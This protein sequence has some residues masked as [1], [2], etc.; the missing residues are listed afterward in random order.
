MRLGGR[1]ECHW[2]EESRA[3]VPSATLFKILKT[4]SHGVGTAILIDI[5]SDIDVE[6]R[7]SILPLASQLTIDIYLWFGHGT[8]EV[9]PCA[10]AVLRHGELGAVPSCA[11]PR[12]RAR[13][14][15]LLSGFLFAILHDGDGLFVDFLVERTCDGPV[16]W[17][18]YLL[19]FTVVE[20]WLRLSR[21]VVV[22]ETP[23]GE[24]G[25]A[26]W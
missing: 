16:V 24:H 26:T 2:T 14:S 23:V 13:T 22:G 11:N 5:R 6:S 7:V 1:H 25:L 21:V 10:T 9:E 20:V 3:R 17:Y 4:H 19:P 15:R 12:E 8:V 18:R